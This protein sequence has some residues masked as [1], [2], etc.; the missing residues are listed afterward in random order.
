VCQTAGRTVRAGRFWLGL[1]LSGAATYLAVRMIDAEQVRQ[2]FGAA[3]LGW[4]MLA[5]AS[6]LATVGAKAARWRA[7][8]PQTSERPRL[9]ALIMAL[10]IGI[11]ANLLA[12]ARVGELARLYVVERLEGRSKALSLSTIAIEKWM[13]LVMLLL[14]FAGLLF[15]ISWP[16]WLATWGRGLASLASVLTVTLV[17]GLFLLDQMRPLA[18]RVT[19]LLPAH[20]GE[21]IMDIWKAA[22]MGLTALRSAPQ[23]GILLGWTLVVWF[24]SAGTNWLLL[25]ALA[26]PPSP[27]IALTLLVILQAG[28]ALPS[29]PAKIGVFHYLT[30]LG[31]GLFSIPSDVALAFAVWLHL[32]VVVLLIGLG[33]LCLIWI[34]F[35]SDKS[36]YDQ[37]DRSGV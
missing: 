29:S 28:S 23:M 13:D 14:T 2:A 21:R 36:Q 3:H 18:E 27:L 9:R 35:S 31:L 15:F 16:A 33:I 30:I 1:A 17:S 7:L 11:M 19:S 25:R 5:L 34:S 26:L 6:V 4:V 32:I 10:S 37:R 8:Y 22:Q 12:P 24:L 20:W